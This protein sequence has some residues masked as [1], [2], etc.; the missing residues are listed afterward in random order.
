MMRVSS[1]EICRHKRLCLTCLSIVRAVAGLEPLK[2]ALKLLDFIVLLEWKQ[3][4]AILIHELG[5]CPD[6]I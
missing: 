5:V 4:W 2:N 6:Y 1:F 3:I